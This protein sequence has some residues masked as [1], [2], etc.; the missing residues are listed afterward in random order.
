MASL[1][2]HC[3]IKARLP[4]IATGRA[5]L[6]IPAAHGNSPLGMRLAR[7]KAAATASQCPPAWLR[8]QLQRICQPLATVKEKPDWI[9]SSPALPTR[10]TAEKVD[11]LIGYSRNFGWNDRIYA[12][13]P[14]ALLNILQETHDTAYH[15][16]LIGHNPGVAQLVSGLCA[17]TDGRIN[18]RFPTAGLAHFEV[19]FARWRQLHW[20]SCELRFLVAPSYLKERKSS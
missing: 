11:E 6:R 10:Q 20:G 13:A 4:S 8:V 17:G 12:A 3:S 7:S 19:D 15:V 9:V 5:A 1:W 14:Y 16:L 18:L 2:H